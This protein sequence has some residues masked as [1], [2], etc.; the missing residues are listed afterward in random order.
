MEFQRGAPVG[1]YK[2]KSSIAVRHLSFILFAFRSDQNNNATC[3]A[4]RRDL[5]T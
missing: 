1:E 5:E 2:N 3:P 4:I